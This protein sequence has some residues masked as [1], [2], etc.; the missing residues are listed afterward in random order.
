MRA[1]L[2]AALVFVSPAA[3]AQGRT[4]HHPELGI[5]ITAPFGWQIER[6]SAYARIITVMAHPDGARLTV[7]VQPLDR[8][9]KLDAF[10]HQNRAAM[11]KA[12]LKV[13]ATTAR[14]PGME[15][16]LTS[17]DGRKRLWQYYVTSGELGFVLTLTAPAADLD[18]YRLAFEYAIKKLE[19]EPEQAD[20]EEALPEPE[21]ETKPQK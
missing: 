20:A 1:V 12:G 19:L 13:G 7:A 11:Q 6:K 16:A 17:K 15:L 18:R 9:R 5:K 2:V 14:P 8:S 3:W 10:V 4:D 21:P